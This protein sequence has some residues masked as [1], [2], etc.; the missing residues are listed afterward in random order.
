[1][2]RLLISCTDDCVTLQQEVGEHS[3]MSFLMLKWLKLSNITAV[4][5]MQFSKT[6]Q[7]FSRHITHLQRPLR[8]II[9]HTRNQEFYLN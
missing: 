5:Q 9:Y 3:V 7:E 1:M 6:L 2:K 8:K 4:R